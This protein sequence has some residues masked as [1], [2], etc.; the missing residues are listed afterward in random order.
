MYDVII[1]GAGVSGTATARELSKYE[2]KICVI[3]KEEDVCCGTSKANSGI[4]HAGFDAKTGSLMAKLNVRGNE[5]MPQIAKDLD[6]PFEQ[7]G[8]LVICTEDEDQGKLEQLYEQGVKNGVKGLRIL[9]K[10]EVREMEENIQDNVVAALYAPTGGI[11]C[12]FTLNLA[13]AENAYDNGVEFFFD[14]EVLNIEKKEEHFV[15]TT[16]QG[17][18]EGKV[19]VNAAGV[20]GDKFHN[21]VS[22][23]KIHIIPRKG[24]YCLLD[25]GTGKMVSHTIFQ[26]PTP[27][28]KGV[29]VTQTVHGNLL[30]GPTALDMEEKDATETTKE[31]L[32]KVMTLSSKS[33]KNIPMRQIITSFAGLRAYEK[34]H[35]FII[36]ELEDVKGFVDC[37]GIASPGLASSPAIGEEVRKIVVSI[38]KPEEKKEYKKTRKGIFDPK[39][40]PLEE[41]K[42]FIR[43]NPLYGKIVCRCEV[44]TEGEIIE[45]IKRPLG[46]KSLDG[47]KRR[48]RAGMGRCQG[49]FC[50]PK[51]MEMIAKERNIS[52]NEVTKKGKNSKMIL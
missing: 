52:M 31:E 16:S 21:M 34:G 45:A 35:D 26:L 38:L 6:V 30:I 22:N 15:V 25:K 4:V 51:I 9:T 1:I 42:E 7:C 10:E 3:E 19:V 36:K 8:S 32:D 18:M 46:A 14:T 43:N 49:G 27:M 28:G 11:V 5:M 12:P 44:V 23:D 50:S 41:R 20:Y 2:L 37:V 40:L 17:K 47:V 29:L 13:Y 24:D 48:V 33:I 39:T